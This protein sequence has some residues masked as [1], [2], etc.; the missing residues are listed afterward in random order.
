M[1]FCSPNCDRFGAR[2]G[3]A[4]RSLPGACLLCP[5]RQLLLTCVALR[6]SREA[7]CGPHEPRL[8]CLRVMRSA[9]SQH[10]TTRLEENDHDEKLIYGGG[11]GGVAVVVHRND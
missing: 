9:P 3:A 8:S 5:K 4:I 2:P 7:V 11:G 6:T 10:I 1:C